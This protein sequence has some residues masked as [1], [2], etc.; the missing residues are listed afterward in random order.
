M[1]EQ[2][3]FAAVDET[4][5]ESAA[6]TRKPGKV[7]PW[8]QLV[9]QLRNGTAHRVPVSGEKA[10]RGARIGIARRARAQGFSVE[11]RVLDGDLLVKRAYETAR[12]RRPRAPT[13]PLPNDAQ[14]RRRGR[15][16]KPRSAE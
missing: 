7:S 6:S 15:P 9:E 1:S 13:T 8:E 4:T 5:W 16:P 12:T 2:P 11:F 10:L 14:P 3:P